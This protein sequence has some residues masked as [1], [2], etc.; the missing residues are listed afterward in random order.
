MNIKLLLEIPK[1]RLQRSFGTI[2]IRLIIYLNLTYLIICPL[3]LFFENE[4]SGQYFPHKVL[5]YV[6]LFAL[7]TNT[8]S[9][10]YNLCK[11]RKFNNRV[12]RWLDSHWEHHTVEF[13]LTSLSLFSLMIMSFLNMVGF[14]NP[15]NDSILADF[16]FGHSL[17]LLSAILIGRKTAFAWFLVVMG[18]LIFVTNRHG[19]NYQFNYLTPQESANYEKALQNKQPW[20]LIRQSELK[21]FSLNSPK[22]TRYFDVWAVLILQAIIIA[23]F[24]NGITNDMFKIIP[25]VTDDIEK[26]II[27][28][29]EQSLEQ[30]KER[31][32]SLK[33]N[34][35]IVETNL[36]LREEIL[37]TE[38][39]FLKS[40][41]NPHFLYNTLNYFYVKASEHDENLAE[42]ILKL[43][44]IMRYTLNDGAKNTV[45][46]GKEIENIK[47]LIDL[48]QIRYN[49]K[50]FIDFEV[51]SSDESKQILPLVLIVLV[52][53][54]LKHGKL[55]DAGYPLSISINVSEE[56]IK[57]SLK[58]RKSAQSKIISTKIGLQNVKRRL[59]LSYP[60]NHDLMIRENEDD[61]QC[62]L[63][64][65]TKHETNLHS[66]G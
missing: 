38:L 16:A 5:G 52:E 22:I 17:I 65:R 7:I 13:L 54:A 61:Y 41:I 39:N 32:K 64:I 28:T 40:Q 53:N 23:Y 55:N 20:A 10:G 49:N 57:F 35:K 48:H 45:A 25:E 46:I 6:Y 1:N 15:S 51:I 59:E 18:T 27:I 37:K 62:Y 29:N 8:I 36:M 30:E 66:I 60:D 56:A 11:L 63:E 24:F 42:S 50:L 34:F 44:D 21:K 14:G 58:N 9:F 3:Y 31:E 26:A 2:R 19:W 43:S 12:I 33:E 47:A 4:T